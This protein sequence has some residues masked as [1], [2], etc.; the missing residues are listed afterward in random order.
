MSFLLLGGA[1][2]SVGR[3]GAVGVLGR[4]NLRLKMSTVHIDISYVHSLRDPIFRCSLLD[5]TFKASDCAARGPGT[6]ATPGP[7]GTPRTPGSVLRHSTVRNFLRQFLLE[8]QSFA[9][10]CKLLAR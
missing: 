9:H 3:G 6:P 7:P 5:M 2:D 8:T 4:G 10:F 1:C